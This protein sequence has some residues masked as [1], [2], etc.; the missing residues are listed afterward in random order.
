MTSLRFNAKYPLVV[1]FLL[2]LFFPPSLEVKANQRRAPEVANRFFLLEESQ[3]L[4]KA[5]SLLDVTCLSSA[6]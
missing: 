3:K 5:R 1:A 4:R 2:L 6:W